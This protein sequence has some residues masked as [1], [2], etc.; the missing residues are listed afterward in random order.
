MQVRNGPLHHEHAALGAK[1]GDFGGWLMPLEYAGGGVLAEHGAVREHVGVFDVS[2]MGTFALQGPDARGAVNEVFTNDLTQ[3]N[4]NGAQYSLLCS[5]TGG[6]VDDLLIYMRSDDD[7]FV[8]PNAASTQIVIA[9]VESILEPTGVVVEDLSASTAIL[10]VQGPQ[11]AELLAELQLPV[12]HDYLTF[13]DAQTQFGPV[14]VAR[15]GYT[16]EHGYEL[17]MSIAAAQELWPRIVQACQAR[18]GLPCGLGARDTLRTEMGYPLYGHELGLEVSPLEANLSWAIGWEK[19]VYVGRAELARQRPQGPARR[20]RALECFDRGVPRPGMSVRRSAGDEQILGTLTS[21]TFSPTLRTGIALAL[22]APDVQIGDE[23]V[24]DVRGRPC[25]ARVVKP[26]F[27]D[28][29]P[30]R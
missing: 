21:G 26:P 20:L 28:A 15:T 7:L 9:T 10:A 18:G 6:V 1:F 17:I 14:T 13:V 2:H 5:A 4:A 12:G 24:I 16:G 8:I 19:L 29:D 11:S 23:V 3:I 22:L 25:R 27:V 30:R